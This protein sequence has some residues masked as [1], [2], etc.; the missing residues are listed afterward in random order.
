[1]DRHFAA[2][3]FWDYVETLL[4]S[5][6]WVIDRLAGSAHPRYPERIYPLDYGYIAGTTAAD[7]D[8]VDIWIG[9]LPQRRLTALVCTVD[10][11]KRDVELKLL[12]GCT[13]TEVQQVLDFH[14]GGS[15]A[16]LLLLPPGGGMS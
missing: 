4:A 7:G 13:L 15:Q 10:L 11:V 12:L 6:E 5:G 1:M 16:A 8:G 14:S 3:H 9:S 2:P